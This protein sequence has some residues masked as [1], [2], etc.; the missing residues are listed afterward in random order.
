MVLDVQVGFGLD[1]R[2]GY[3][4]E[5]LRAGGIGWQLHTLFFLLSMCVCVCVCVCWAEDVLIRQLFAS[6]LL[7]EHQKKPE[8]HFEM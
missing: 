6:N 4:Q 2:F 3:P 5:V 7:V 8:L 1:Q